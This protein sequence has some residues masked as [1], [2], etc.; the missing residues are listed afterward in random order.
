MK[1]I[2]SE[3]K[4]ISSDELLSRTK[5][6]VAEERRLYATQGFGSMWEFCTRFL[7]LSEGSAQRRLAAMRLAY[8]APEAKA[9]LE[10]GALSLS[11]AAK[12]H[13]FRQNQKKQ[14]K[15]PMPAQELIR[16]VESM[17]QRE[18]EAKLHEISPEALPRERERIV[19][20]EKEHELKIVISD[21][22]Y[23]NLQLIKGLLAHAFVFGS[24]SG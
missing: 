7:G 14:G 9:A 18:C 4:N 6:I 3:L 13:S 23:Q 15:S 8:D 2:H 5:N 20:A 1:T 21:E 12:I 24:R 11:N 17:S 16:Q 19:S 10:S 22:V